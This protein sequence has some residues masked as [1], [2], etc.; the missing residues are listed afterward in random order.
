MV[1][2]VVLDIGITPAAN[3]GAG[4]GGGGAGAVGGAAINEYNR[5][6]W[7]CW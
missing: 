2:M 4:G 1:L 3:A 7:W 6:R 5:Q